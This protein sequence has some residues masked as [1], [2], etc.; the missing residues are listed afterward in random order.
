L[1]KIMILKAN[2]PAIHKLGNIGRNIDDKIRIH[3]EDENNYIGNFEEGFGFI[4]VKFNKSD[5]RPLTPEERENL[6]GSWYGINGNPLYRIYVDEEGNIINGKV[7]TVK[8]IV[9]KVTDNLGKDKHSSFVN[10]N[11]EFGED[12]LIGRSLIML[13]GEGSIITS[14]VTNFE[15]DNGQYVIYTKNSVYYIDMNRG[16]K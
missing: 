7:L 16:G 9:S 2:S 8:G 6:N 10:L 13:T 5:C 4:N 12:I 15:L 14:K 11:V 3:S 1:N